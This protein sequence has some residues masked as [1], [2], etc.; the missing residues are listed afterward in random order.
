MSTIG[1]SLSPLKNLGGSSNRTSLSLSYTRSSLDNT[2]GVLVTTV[3]G[4]SSPDDKLLLR[5]TENLTPK[6]YNVISILEKQHYRI[7]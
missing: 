1:K 7:G 6:I 2:S 5:V 3:E 4:Q